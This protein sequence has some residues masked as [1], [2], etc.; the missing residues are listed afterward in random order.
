MNSS[1][2]INILSAIL[3]CTP[4]KSWCVVA[5]DEIKKPMCFPSC[6]ISN[7]MPR[8]HKGLHWIA[9]Y[10]KN[11]NT[12]EYWDSY[13]NSLKSYNIKLHVN[14][15]NKNVLQKYNSNVCGLYCV[16]F[17]ALRSQ[18]HSFNSIQKCFTNNKTEN[19]IVVK[20]YFKNLPVCKKSTKI[21]CTDQTCQKFLE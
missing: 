3:P 20:E 12:V 6:I 2:L 8:N 11:K 21:T 14:K 13:G 10:Y 4:V 17:L 1:S 5:S 19:D 16:M 15:Y 9:F 7:T 18:G